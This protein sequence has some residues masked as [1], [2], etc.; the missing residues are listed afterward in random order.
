MSLLKVVFAVLMFASAANASERTVR[1]AAVHFEPVEGDVARN[2]LRLVQLTRDAARSGAKIVVH[3]EMATSGY[4]FFSRE[5]IARVAERIPGPSTRALGAVAK[6]Y[7]IYVAVGLPEYDPSLNLYFNSVALLGPDGGIVGVYRKRNN[8]LEASYNSEVWS[9]VPTFNTPYGRIAI[10]ICADMFYTAFPRLAAV[11]GADILLAPANVGITT[12]F[13][14]ARTWENDFSMIVANRFGHGSQ[15]SKPTYFNQNSFAIPSP[16]AYDFSSSQSVIMSHKQE[17]LAAVSDAKIQI[18]YGDLPIRR[19]R[20]LPVVRR[21]QLYSL[22][23]QDT[24]EPYTFGQ[25]HL[26]PAAKFAVAG[27]DPGPQSDPWGAA[28]RASNDAIAAAGAQGMSLRLIVLPS[29]YLPA[30]SSD[31]IASLKSFATTNNV[32][33]VVEF[34]NESPPKSV[35]IASNG[36]TYSYF[37]THRLREERIPD[38]KLSSDFWI[39]DRDYARVALLQDVDLMAPETSLMMEKLGVD[40]VALNSDTSLPIVSALWQTRTG[41]YYNIVAAN[42]SGREG[43][44]LGGYPP[45]PQ[46]KEGDGMVLMQVDTTYVRAKKEARFLDFRSLLE[47]CKDGSC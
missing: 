40:I 14:K 9:P 3:T 5:E 32:D 43:V 19:T 11:A 41:D 8:L 31:G 12:D 22:L 34:G 38:S 4:S 44:Y 13:M 39:V 20:T 29:N 25:F 35:M 6:K 36:D 17:V 30:Q 16:F 27:V 26:P 18:A 46:F 45:G 33:L 21:P 47:H 15:G 28:V 1:V 23:G 24:L 42:R 37:R 10:V 2:V 7:G